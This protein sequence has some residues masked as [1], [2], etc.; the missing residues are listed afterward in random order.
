M[1]Y[2]DVKPGSLLG[3]LKKKKALVLVHRIIAHEEGITLAEARH[4]TL[5][6]LHS[7]LRI[8][9]YVQQCLLCVV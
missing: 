5:F 4:L 1:Y 2:V 7:L 6:R 9:V 8:D 3:S